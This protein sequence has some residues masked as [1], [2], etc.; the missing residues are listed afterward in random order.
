[1]QSSSGKTDTSQKYYTQIFAIA[2]PIII[3]GMV[4]QAQTLINRA[5]LGNLKT[6]YLSAIGNVSF[7]YQATLS[8]VISISTGL[9]ILISRCA[10]A[11]DFKQARGYMHTSIVFSSVFS[12]LLFT[13][14]YFLANTI[15]LAMGVSSSLIDYCDNYMK[16][17]SL[18]LL[19]FG[20][21]ISV[22][23]SLQGVGKTK[24][25]MYAGIYK[26]MMNIFLD[27]CLIFGNLGMPQL[28]MEGAAIAS[29]I[30]NISSAVVLILY[31]F[32]SKSLPIKARLTELVHPKLSQYKQIMTLGLP[33]GFELMAWYI[34]SLM[35]IR[36]MNGLSESAVAMF[37]II[38]SIEG[39]TFLISDGIARGSLT[40]IGY[41]IGEGKPKESRSVIRESILYNL[42]IITVAFAFFVLFS[43]QILSLFTNDHQ[44][45]SSS[46]FYF[47]LVCVAIFPKS[48]CVQVGT[49]IRAFGDAKWMLF[50][51]VVGTFFVIASAYTLVYVFKMDIFAVY[52]TIFLDEILRSAWNAFHLKTARYPGFYSE[53]TSGEIRSTA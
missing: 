15:F 22:Q 32:L 43:R 4:F 3:Q 50:T 23:A 35:L 16:I 21:D 29:T 6:E 24:P 38:T 33:T 31:M 11:K 34:G 2:I 36:L 44:L 14:W 30:S 42:S 8:V 27:W 28:G 39:M 10:G 25:I 19:I 48:L 18:Y 52:L 46:V 53:E 9:T 40:L 37:T 49:G 51:Q 20:V 26:V 1:M 17:L 5:F 45:I 12:T 47:I 41:K 7:P 13:V